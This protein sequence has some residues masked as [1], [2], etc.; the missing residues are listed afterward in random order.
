M[1][2]GKL[3]YELFFCGAE[4]S[5]FFAH[6]GKRTKITTNFQTVIVMQVVPKKASVIKRMGFAFA[7]LAL[8]VG[9]AT[10]AM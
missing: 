3:I 2:F 10:N 8:L 6:M 4:I 7:K 5:Q 1:E 9:A